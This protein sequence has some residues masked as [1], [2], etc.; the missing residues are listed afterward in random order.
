MRARVNR[1]GPER[2]GDQILL[3]D[4][5]VSEGGLSGV[6]IRA[7]IP[8]GRGAIVGRIERAGPGK[9]VDTPD[10]VASP[11]AQADATAHPSGHMSQQFGNVGRSVL[12]TEGIAPRDCGLSCS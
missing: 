8:P 5:A 4:S 9:F 7:V 6:R 11:S 3:I 12:S 2:G 1:T 10:S